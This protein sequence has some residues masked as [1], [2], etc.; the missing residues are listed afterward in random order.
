[1]RKRAKAVNFGIVYGISG[2]SLSKDVGTSVAEATRYIKSYMMNYPS[3]EEYLDRVVK[4]AAERGYTVTEFGRRR[5]IPELSSQNG[6]LRAFGKR[7]AM[8][9]PIQGTAADIMKLA[10][11]NVYRRLKS[12]GLD[13]RI[14][15]QVHD[16]L[17]VEVADSQLDICKRILK[18]E[19]E[20]AASLS[21][22]L[23]ADVTSGKNWLE[24]E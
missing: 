7:V 22:P 11:I 6:N 1:M 21:I 4:E 18:E 12:E 10:M 20:S 16:E 19:M 2:F 13:A 24:Q 14:V 23:V 5:Y 3:I 8:N 9:A 17:V 15:M